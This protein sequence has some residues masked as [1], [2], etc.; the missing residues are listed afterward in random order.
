VVRIAD[1]PVRCTNMKGS[2]IVAAI[3]QRRSGSVRAIEGDPRRART[4]RTDA[5]ANA[6][7]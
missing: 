7:R 1:N 3:S 2:R 4:A 5:D 6:G